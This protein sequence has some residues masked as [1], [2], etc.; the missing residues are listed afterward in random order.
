MGAALAV[1][2][3][4]AA[5]GFRGT[6]IRLLP[7]WS[8][9]PWRAGASAVVKLAY[10]EHICALV[11]GVD[12]DSTHLAT[13]IAAKALFPVIDAVSTDE[14]ANHAG[15]PW[16][17]SWAPGNRQIARQM[18]DLLGDAPFLLV[19]ETDHDSRM[20][21][22]AFLKEGTRQ[23]V[24]RMDSSNV[25][26]AGVPG[27]ADQVVVIAPPARTIACA[28]AFPANT[29]IVAGP[30]ASSRQC[31]HLAGRVKTPA[32]V[33][34][35]A[36]LWKR[37]EC[38]FNAPADAF[39]QLSFEATSMLIHV[40]QEVGPSRAA[41]REALASRRPPGGRLQPIPPNPIEKEL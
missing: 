17:F 11:G 30:A 24:L 7:R 18:R 36:L 33:Q 19:S 32:L 21:A 28:E 14:S 27:D 1:E 9:D 12:S 38:R 16:I 34:P 2:D 39:A 10:E 3:A 37:L 13:Q 20:L 15:V 6:P 5:G 22:S 25:S 26:H 29:R 40:I 41:V 4:N 23:P 35:D 8:D 31:I